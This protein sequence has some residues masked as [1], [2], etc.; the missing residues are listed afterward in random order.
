MTALA[1]LWVLVYW[2]WEPS[3]PK[4]SFDET[5]AAHPPPVVAPA[6]PA[7]KIPPAIQQT[8]RTRGSASP[9]PARPTQAA[10]QPKQAPLAVIPP[11][12]RAYTIKKGDT[13]ESI[14]ASELGASKFA[15]SISKANPNVSELRMGREIRIPIDPGN[16]QGRPVADA[17]TDAPS[18]PSTEYVVKTGDTLGGIAKAYYGS[19]SYKDLIFQANRDRLE[20]E[21]ELKVGQKLRLP[22]KPG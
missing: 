10:E 18:V 9:P 20:Q 6:G 5:P 12:F 19:T 8:P 22:P 17:A 13:W 4:I 3:N 21:D 1:A 2:W 11:Q 14:A 15:L 7:P 16:I